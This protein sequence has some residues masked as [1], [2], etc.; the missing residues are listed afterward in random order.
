[1]TKYSTLNVPTVLTSPTDYTIAL[2]NAGVGGGVVTTVAVVA[3]GETLTIEGNT[4]QSQITPYRN[5]GDFFG[6]NHE[7]S[8]DKITMI[9]QESFEGLDR[10]VQVSALDDGANTTLPAMVANTVVSINPTGDGFTLTSFGSISTDIDTAITTPADDDLLHYNVGSG[11][12]ENITLTS[13]LDGLLSASDDD[14]LQR[15][16]G[17]W[18][19][20]TIAQLVS[21]LAGAMIYVSADD[22]TAGYLNGK[23]VAGTHTALTENN[24][25]ANETLTV[26]LSARSKAAVRVSL[27]KLL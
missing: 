12:W 17:T 5:Q 9:I 20:R 18:T 2:T 23:I 27:F 8:F 26:D 22:T 4:P 19:N 13:Y 6:L 24:G 15:K 10:A 1:V 3:S 21:D 7:N 16:S 11:L 14:I 25:G